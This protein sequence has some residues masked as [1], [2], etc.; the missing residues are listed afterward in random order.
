MIP[1]I[2]LENL[3]LSKIVCGT[4]Q[5]VAITHRLNYFDILKHKRFYNDIHVVAKFITHLAVNYGINCIV[6]S[7]RQKIYD[8]IKMT[9][10]ETGEKIHWICTPSIRKTVK[11]LECDIFKQIDW[12]AEHDVSVCM[13]HR[14]YTDLVLDKETLKIGGTEI[15][16]LSR[17]K[18][19]SKIIAMGLHIYD[20]QV[21]KEKIKEMWS[22]SYSDIA[23]HI[24]DGRM[25]PG[26]ST[27]YIE[28]ILA[29]EKHNYDAPLIIQPLNLKGYQSNVDPK[30]L[31]Q[32]I[33]DTNLQILNIKPMAAGRLK[34]HP[35]FEFCLNNIKISDFM[36]FG[37]GTSF[38]YM[39]EDIKIIQDILVRQE[40]NR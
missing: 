35:A 24:R 28:S 36:S 29:V 11:E 1:K 14:I 27:H 9:E 34:P 18:S 25:I 23:A 10:N 39:V 21:P 13:P 31:V 33:K 40:K 15:N 26:L 32:V 4:N 37:F 16:Q 7:P 38:D 20:R 12:C 5:F 2:P 6:S 17:G 30:R 8:A 22:I 3:K 19:I